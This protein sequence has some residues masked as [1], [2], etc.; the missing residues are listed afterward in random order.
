MEGVA[1][2]M[3]EARSSNTYLEDRYQQTDHH[4]DSPNPTAPLSSAVATAAADWAEVRRFEVR[5][6]HQGL[7]ALPS[8][9]LRRLTGGW[10]VDLW[11]SVGWQ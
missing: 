1:T 3:K 6:S 7:V 8:Q 5:D 10:R 2:K 11:V 9:R 4:N